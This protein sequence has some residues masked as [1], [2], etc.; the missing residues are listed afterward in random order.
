ML[1][2]KYQ[3]N[4]Q[5]YN[6]YGLYIKK[7]MKQVDKFRYELGLKAYNALLR[8]SKRH[9]NVLPNPEIYAKLF[10]GDKQEI[11][12]K[13]KKS[14]TD[15]QKL[16]NYGI[17]LKKLNDK[18]KDKQT[19]KEGE[20]II[21]EADYV[22]QD[23]LEFISSINVL[24]LDIPLIL[25]N[26]QS[27]LSDL[28]TFIS[29]LI[30]YLRIEYIDYLLGELNVNG[31]CAVKYFKEQ[32]ILYDYS[33]INKLG[34]EVVFI[35]RSN[36]NNTYWR[37]MIME[38]MPNYHIV[39]A[40]S[41]STKLTFD[42]HKK[43]D[44]PINMLGIIKTELGGDNFKVGDTLGDYYKQLLLS[45]R[46]MI[47]NNMVAYDSKIIKIDRIGA[48]PKSQSSIVFMNKYK[49]ALFDEGLKYINLVM[50]GE[51]GTGKT[52]VCDFI[53]DERVKLGKSKIYVIDSD[54]YGRWRY[55]YYGLGVPEKGE[56]KLPVSFDIIE[57]LS[58]EL[59]VYEEYARF[60]MTKYKINSINKI[61]NKS[62][63]AKNEFKEYYIKHLTD[64][65]YATESY[66]V[67]TLLS[68]INVDDVKPIIINQLHTTTQLPIAGRT[69]LVMRLK[70]INDTEIVNIK[71][72][73]E[74]GSY[75]E[76]FLYKIYRELLGDNYPVLYPYEMTDLIKY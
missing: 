59:S 71:R 51:K 42:S 1:G 56:E 57:R 67:N 30:P 14:K 44:D 68:S 61:D 18:K 53:N 75:D 9:N 43:F 23:V 72:G 38:I 7:E 58:E 47:D 25:I 55:K 31:G 34:R 3:G 48:L 74:S 41:L 69:R 37:K 35:N 17:V 32:L 26:N 73:V 63:K 6:N 70:T 5:Y 64:G 2:I 20:A 45:G 19:L 22:I 39:F 24:K 21:D 62:E 65:D 16:N 27:Y 46:P 12:I 15:E 13:V 11:V 33:K 54:A 10:L 8:I 49:N 60:I 40:E 28:P 52:K 76:Y 50:L 4:E 29:Q 66:F 36:Y